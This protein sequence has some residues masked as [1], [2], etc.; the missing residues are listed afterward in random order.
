[1]NADELVNDVLGSLDKK[2]A[3]KKQTVYVRAGKG[4]KPCPSCGNYVGVRTLL[5]ECGHEFVI[6]ASASAT[7]ADKNSAFEEPLSDEDKRYI[8]AIG[9]GKGGL[10]IYTGAGVSPARL[11]S[12]DC[13]AVCDFCD[14]VVFDGMGKGK[15]YMP[16][17]IKSFARHAA[18]DTDMCMETVADLIDDWYESK[19]ESTLGMEV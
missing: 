9:C 5:C 1:M 8:R 12:Q 10:V 15:I 2:H 3:P 11:N 16:S 19:V 13:E 18:G 14:Q 7:T 6:G 4:R 17:A